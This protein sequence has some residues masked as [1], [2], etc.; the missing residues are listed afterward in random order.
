MFSKARRSDSSQPIRLHIGSGKV[1]LPGW[2]NVDIQA[3]P[4]VDV[5]ADVTKGLHYTDVEAIFAE[6]FLEHLAIDDALKFLQESHHAL[7]AGG[8][9]RLS[10]PN[11]DWVWVTHYRLEAD[12][13]MKRTYALGLNRA[14]HG[15]RHRFLWNREMLGEAL[16]ACGFEEPR[17]CRYGESGL[18]LFQGIEHHE[19][20]QDA[21]ELP[22]V[23][24][25]EAR[26][27]EPRPER[28]RAF[29]ERIREGFLNHMAD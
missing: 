16:L 21:P 26:K 9:I 4:G 25:A 18:D 22:H 1:R 28:L 10:T 8:W 23:I 2:L 19:V 29:E 12:E 17:W 7:A 11:L 15:W 6:H 13:E 20:Y 14:F 5:V 27:G 3:L 24:I